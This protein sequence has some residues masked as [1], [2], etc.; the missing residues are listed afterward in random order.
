MLLI[1]EE[2]FLL[3]LDEEKGSLSSFVKKTI[4]CGLS[5]AILAELALRGKVCSNDKHR[6]ELADDTLTGDELLDEALEEIRSSEK[7]RKLTYWVSQ[8]SARP[9]KF[10]ER[11]GERLVA[12]NILYQEDKRLFRQYSS[13]HDSQSLAPSK[14]EIKYPLR[15]MILSNQENDHRSLALL[16]VAAAS[17]LLNLI[18]T[19]DELS[20]AKR[21]IHEKVL[22]AALENPAMETIEE[23]EQAVASSLEDD[24][25]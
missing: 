5:G 20:I 24:T 14:F 21:L 7:P 4:G 9:K 19:Q 12:K 16:K 11:L 6:L 10:R 22:R 15:A 17:E 18:F 3:A 1:I 23:I 13:T 2:L 8:F 25:D